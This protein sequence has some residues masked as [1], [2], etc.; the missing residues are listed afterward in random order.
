ME[1]QI[2][3]KKQEQEEVNDLTIFLPQEDKPN[4][5]V[6]K[7]PKKVYKHNPFIVANTKEINLNVLKNDCIIPVFSKDNEKTIA[8]QEFIQVT[9]DCVAKVFPH[10]T[11]ELPEVRTSHQ[12]KGRTAD[13]IYKNVNE[14]LDH[15]K[16][17]YFERMAFIIRIPSITE[18][19]NGQELSLVVGGVRAYNKENLY[20]KKSYE[21]FQVFIGFQNMVCCNLCISTDGFK[22]EIRVG[23]YLELQS[24][25]LDLIQGYNAEKHL[26][27]M[28]ELS[29][30]TMTETQ[31]A[32]LIGKAK[33]YNYL[34]K[35]EKENIPEL[36]LIDSQISTIAKDYYQ[37]KSFS[38]N[39]DGD[40]N[41]WNVYN[42]F[43]GANKGS[44]IDSFLSRNVNAFDFSKG[45]AK[46]LSDGGNSHHWFLS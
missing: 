30:Q 28:K 13:A 27:S 18:T 45:L 2:V 36:M 15:E 39:D 8:H 4:V 26:E 29:Q 43:T 20:S 24:Q 32:Q 23:S 5:E 10:H 12:I 3:S 33:L 9:Q 41:L 14:L 19:I 11:I 16:T 25:I 38:R 42:L 17:Q 21:K 44:Y 6:I 46:T 34:P 40:I 22:A 37:D 7:Q 35:E 1:L 31:F